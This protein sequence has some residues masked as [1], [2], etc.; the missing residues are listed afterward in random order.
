M[1]TT[2]G[3][4]PAFALHPVTHL[5]LSPG[6]VTCPLSEF[7]RMFPSERANCEWYSARVPADGTVLSDLVSAP[8]RGTWVEGKLISGGPPGMEQ[9]WAQKKDRGMRTATG[10]RAGG[11][12]YLVPLC[13]ELGVRCTHCRRAWSWG[14]SALTV[15]MLVG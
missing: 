1:T 12:V 4:S 2:L 3:G 5:P 7:S 14:Y 6:G 15:L 8:K 9:P 11:T 13:W 10:H